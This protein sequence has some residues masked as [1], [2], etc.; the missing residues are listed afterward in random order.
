MSVNQLKSKPNRPCPRKFH[1]LNASLRGHIICSLHRAILGDKSKLK[2]TFSS[3][4]SQDEESRFAAV[5]CQS[6]KLHRKSHLLSQASGNKSH[7]W[8]CSTSLYS[9]TSFYELT[10][11]ALINTAALILGISVPH[12]VFLQSQGQNYAN[13]DV[14]GDSLLNDPAHAG[15]TRKLTHNKMAR[16]LT[17]IANKCGISTTCKGSKLPYRDAGRPNQTRKRADMMTLQGGCVQPNHRL[18]FSRSTLLIMDVT[19]GHV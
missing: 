9:L 3:T 13:I 8:Q 17:K 2:S 10:N 12:A 7:L 18:N 1:H 14:W 19:I 15:D 5:S 6:L 16:E 4:L 11:D